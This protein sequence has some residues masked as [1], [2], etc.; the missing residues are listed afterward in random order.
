MPGRIE[1]TVFISYRRTNFWT[2]LAV[3]QN[4]HS[5]GYD[6]FFDYKSIPSGDFE[7]VIIENIR[8]RAHFL[9][10]LSTSALDRCHEPGDW[11]RREIET[12]IDSKRNIIP[13]M[14]DG[15]DF[16]SIATTRALIGK[17]V[18][19]KNYN[20]LGIPGEYFEE[21]MVK[22]KSDKFLNRPLESVVH[23][24]SEVT[25]RITAVQKL[26]ANRA[27]P[28]NRIQITAEEWYERGNVFRENYNYDESIRC[29]EEALSIKPDFDEA[30]IMLENTRRELRLR[31][32]LFHK[33]ED[34]LSKVA[35]PKDIDR[36]QAFINVLHQLDNKEPRAAK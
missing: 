19:L 33:I 31:K 5:S 22:L 29:Y 11:L 23:P 2:A 35:D 18:K 3:F 20:G 7:Q 16:G 9:V 32:K 28:V 34:D 12:A 8:S 15:F 26:A 36:I 27:A 17:L 6:V 14:M 24:V 10:I 25:T 13:L 30:A 21:A 4:L 1:K